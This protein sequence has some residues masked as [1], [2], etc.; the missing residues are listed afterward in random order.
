MARKMYRLVLES[1]ATSWDQIVQVLGLSHDICHA[2]FC[3]NF[4]APDI[5][6][7]IINGYAPPGLSVCEIV[8][9]VPG[10]GVKSESYG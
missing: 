5:V 9:H 7:G 3:L 8:K 1:N 6:T 2:I 10:H 4:L